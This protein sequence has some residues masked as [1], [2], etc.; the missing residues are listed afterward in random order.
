MA[1]ILRRQAEI[2]ALKDKR[3][4]K[5]IGQLSVLKEIMLS[6]AQDLFL[7]W[8]NLRIKFWQIAIA[9]H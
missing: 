5:E 3:T 6:T 8:I 1:N 9:M 4:I 7:V 2:K